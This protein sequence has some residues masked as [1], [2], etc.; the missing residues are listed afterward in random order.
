MRQDGI[1]MSRVYIAKE[2]LGRACEEVL[3]LTATFCLTATIICSDVI[4]QRL[5]QA[6]DPDPRHVF[7]KK[8]YL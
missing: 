6:W 5:L 2:E 4:V 7:R 3:L 1:L 8:K